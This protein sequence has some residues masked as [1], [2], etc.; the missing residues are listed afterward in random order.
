MP[1]TKASQKAVSK[2]RKKNYDMIQIS[3]PKGQ[4]DII[5]SAADAA[6]ESVNA[7]IKKA[8]TERMERDNK[9]GR[10]E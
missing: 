6:G 4:R 10:T 9:S 1:T 3:V 5:K 2:Y 8:I 7:Y